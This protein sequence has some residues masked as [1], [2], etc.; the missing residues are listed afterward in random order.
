MAG[1]YQSEC[2]R[3]C[4]HSGTRNN[5]L[6]L[7]NDNL[8]SGRQPHN[9]L[10][11]GTAAIG[12][13]HMNILAEQMVECGAGSLYSISSISQNESLV[14]LQTE[15]NMTRTKTKSLVCNWN[16][17]C[18]EAAACMELMWQVHDICNFMMD[19]WHSRGHNYVPGRH[20]HQLKFG[21]TQSYFKYSAKHQA[22]PITPNWCLPA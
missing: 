13:W 17:R 16:A 2:Q 20:W 18:C 19:Q 21:Y 8:Y 1:T 14:E 5:R 12:N 15:T 3:A 22:K 7:H 9:W 10:V 6:F 11:D 4:C